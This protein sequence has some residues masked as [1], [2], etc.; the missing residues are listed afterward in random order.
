MNRAFRAGP[1]PPHVLFFPRVTC[2]YPALGHGADATMGRH[3]AVGG[4]QSL[5]ALVAL[6]QPW[7]RL[8]KRRWTLDRP[9]ATIGS[10]LSVRVR[11]S[12]ERA[13][14]PPTQFGYRLIA[15]SWITS[16]PSRWYDPEWA[17]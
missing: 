11:P 7:T 3:P 16:E 5:G 4:A 12:S 9:P 17:R 13:A 10:V 2:C 8:H 15:T 6:G 1:R 14:W